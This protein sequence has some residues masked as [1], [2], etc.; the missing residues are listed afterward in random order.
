MGSCCSML[1]F[2]AKSIKWKLYACDRENGYRYKK[3]L[4]QNHNQLTWKDR[5]NITYAIIYAIIYIHDEKAI[6]RD[7]YSGNIL[8]LHYWYI[9]DLGFCGPANKS[10]SIYGNLPHIAPEVV[11]CNFEF[12]LFLIIFFHL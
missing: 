2:N 12:V 6:H 11:Q 5:I 9:G 4:Q 7:L 1:W 10:S 3:Y 8:Y